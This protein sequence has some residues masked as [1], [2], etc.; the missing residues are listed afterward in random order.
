MAKN[1]NDLT[2]TD[3]ELLGVEEVGGEQV[4]LS[5]SDIIVAVGRGVGGAD[6]MGP[7]EELAKV[8]GAQENLH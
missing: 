4:D 5:K 2:T 3:R 6:K 7:A 8:L 1:A